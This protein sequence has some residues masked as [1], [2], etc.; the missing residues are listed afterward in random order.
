LGV[1]PI[2]VYNQ[3]TVCENGS[4]NGT[5]QPLYAKKY[6]DRGRP[7]NTWKRRIEKELGSMKLSWSEAESKAQDR[8]E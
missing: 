5:S 7:K 2:G 1:P 4:E 3:N 8:A 6:R